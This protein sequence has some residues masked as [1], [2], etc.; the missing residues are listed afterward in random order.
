M[1]E[2]L[3]AENG[4]YYLIKFSGNDNHT[5][6][7]PRRFQYQWENWSPHYRFRNEIKKR[8]E[9]K[10][11]FQGKWEKFNETIWHSYDSYTEKNLPTPHY[12]RQNW[13]EP[14]LK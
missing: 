1:K 14:E 2:S 10:Q 3:E 8:D 11:I 12:T 4:R 7:D 5:L 13:E 6:H 9:W